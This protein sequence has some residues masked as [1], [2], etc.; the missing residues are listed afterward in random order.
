M[1]VVSEVA[2]AGVECIVTVQPKNR[3]RSIQIG[4]GAIKPNGF[5]FSSGTTGVPKMVLHPLSAPAG[6]IERRKH[7]LC[8]LEHLLRHSP[9]RRPADFFARASRRGIAGAVE[10]PGID[11]GLSGRGLARKA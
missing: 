4:A 7:N 5:S 1:V 11:R 10:H 8:P 3:A 2:N 9:L 6:A